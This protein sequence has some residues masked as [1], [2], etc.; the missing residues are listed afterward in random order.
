MYSV[1]LTLVGLSNLISG[2][3]PLFS[4]NKISK[5][6][7]GDLILIVTSAMHTIETTS[8]CTRSGFTVARFLC[9]NIVSKSELLDHMAQ[10]SICHSIF[11]HWF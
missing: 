8:I 11:I 6:I 9:I 1:F 4:K 5:L 10:I 7:K 2:A 3:P